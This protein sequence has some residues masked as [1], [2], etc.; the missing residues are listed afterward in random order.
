MLTVQTG[1]ASRR[2][3]IANNKYFSHIPVSEKALRPVATYPPVNLRK[4]SAHENYE[5]KKPC[6]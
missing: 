6:V 2:V 1:R 4:V 5:N 3:P